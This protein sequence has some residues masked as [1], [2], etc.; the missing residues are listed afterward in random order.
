MKQNFVAIYSENNEINNQNDNSEKNITTQNNNSIIQYINNDDNFIE[1]NVD[2][3]TIV[4][5]ALQTQLSYIKVI[6]LNKKN[7]I[8][9]IDYIEYKLLDQSFKINQFK[10]FG[11]GLF[12][13]F[14]YLLNLLISYG[15]LLIFCFIYIVDIFFEYY[16]KVKEEMN[17]Y[18]YYDILTLT[19]GSQVIKFRKFYI[20]NYGE[21]EFL[22]KY[23]NFD[24]FY[25][26]YGIYYF[27]ASYFIN[28]IFM[29]YLRKDYQK[30]KIEN[31]EINDYTLILSG[32]KI[33]F[34]NKNENEGDLL[35]NKKTLKIN[36]K[37]FE[38]DDVTYTYKSS[39][40]FENLKKLNEN[41]E[42]CCCYKCYNTRID[43]RKIRCDLKKIWN[44]EKEENKLYIITFNNKKDY[45]E[46][47]KKYSHS[48]FTNFLCNLCKKEK[49]FIYI[50]KAPKP[51]DILWENLENG[52]EYEYF[53][54]KFW[55]ILYFFI[56]LSFSFV[57]NIVQEIILSKISDKIKDSIGKKL[58]RIISIILNIILGFLL[59][60][61][62]EKYSSYLNNLLENK[63]NFW[64]NSEIKFNLI[65][66]NSIFKFISKGLFPFITNMIIEKDDEFYEALV[67]KMFTIIEMDG[68]GYPMIDLICTV[69]KKGKEMYEK[70]KTIL[71]IDNINNVIYDMNN[72]PNG[73]SVSELKKIYSKKEMELDENYSDII[74]IYWISMF[75]MSIYPVGMIQ[76]FLNLLFKYIIEKNFLMYIYKRPEFINPKIGFFCF[77]FAN[78]GFFFFLFG[79]Y[80]FFKNE[81]N[82]NCFGYLYILVMILILIFPFFLLGKLF[83]IIVKCCCLKEKIQENEEIKNVEKKFKSNYKIFE[84]FFVKDFIIKKFDYF[85]ENKK[86]QLLEESQIEKLRK[87]LENLKP[88][89]LYN[90]Q[91]KLRT[92]KFMEFEEKNDLYEEPK[93][94]DDEKKQMYLFLFELELI[95]YIEEGPKKKEILL[96]DDIKSNSLKNLY[97]QENLSIG[98][99]SYFCTFYDNNSLKMAYIYKKEEDKT[100][101][102]KIYDVFN[103]RVLDKDNLNNLNKIICIDCFEKEGSIFIVTIDLNNEMKIYDTKQKM[104]IKT[105]KNV[106]DDFDDINKNNFFSLS[107]VKH[108]VYNKFD[109]WIITSYNQ[110][111]YFK[112]F[113][114]NG[115]LLGKSESLQ[116]QNQNII[117]IQSLYYTDANC[118][119]CVRTKNKISLYINEIFIRDI[120][121]LNSNI[122]YYLNFKI[123][124]INFI[125]KFI[126]V[127]CIQKDLT[128]YFLYKIEIS[129]IFPMLVLKENANT[130]ANDFFSYSW[131]NLVN[132]IINS[133]EYN[134]DIDTP[135]NEEIKNKIINNLPTYE[136]SQFN[137]GVSD[138]KK[139]I[140]KNKE[141]DIDD[142]YNIGN[143]L[144]WE[145]N[146]LIVGTPFNFFHVIDYEKKTIV[147]IISDSE[148]IIS[149]NISNVIDDPNYG[150][151][152]IMRDNKG[153]IQYIRPAVIRDKLNYKIY[154]SN[155]YFNE[156]PDEKKL[157]FINFS[158]LFY[159]L[160][161][162]LSYTLPL[163]CG[164]ISYL[165]KNE[166]KNKHEYYIFY[167]FYI[168]F[169]MFF[170][171]CV[172]D[173]CDNSYSQKKCCI[174]WNIATLILKI[175]GHCFVA[176]R[177]CSDNKNGLIFI[178]IL[179]GMFLIHFIT[180]FI[181]YYFK[182]KFLLKNYWLNFLFYQ[183]SRFSILLFF[184]LCHVYNI[185]YFETYI[186][187]FILS[188][189]SI[190]IFMSNYFYMFF[191]GIFYSSALQAIFNFPFEWLNLCCVCCKDPRNCVKNYDDQI[192]YYGCI[193]LCSENGK[194]WIIIKRI[195][196]VFIII[197][198]L[199]LCIGSII[200]FI[201]LIIFI[202][203]RYN[204]NKDK[205]EENNRILYG[206]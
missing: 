53:K 14:L 24:V 38:V 160:Y 120:I 28:I 44:K 68:F 10:E 102:L 184:I 137:F 23:Q 132:Y 88:I 57:I 70:S 62:D 18:Y 115:E 29:L 98:N 181:I 167:A 123:L 159:L 109:F 169:G 54:N 26:K 142:K 104:I 114:S 55:K 206:N 152:F 37:I 165:S 202:Y 148:N 149:Y 166:K 198:L 43:I 190:Y 203:W 4:N 92:Q 122:D 41:N 78:I 56:F 79:N 3:K 192:R 9:K 193:N 204:K 51:E 84:P 126:F 178:S 173:I 5:D 64:S 133:I 69:G 11:Y 135:I 13:F 153:K 176:Y 95:N 85:K 175:I 1:N 195:F 67:S 151:S 164:I 46:I 146:Y 15:I 45:D 66:Y 60:K 183:I 205:I 61:L 131:N 80:I 90:I 117:S 174:G 40:Y 97:M 103:K 7:E 81:Y 163:L 42:N 191:K 86:K 197:F 22:K 16:K 119:I 32:E 112:I 127:S 12:V 188:I 134:N 140:Y 162:V 157:K 63:S 21:N 136:Y 200:L 73:L 35:K 145:K 105:I 20:E 52:L 116:D 48:Y 199:I 155:E 113:D 170:K 172:Y 130:N 47:Y 187:A 82:K 156:L 34:D 39:E 8:P 50:T 83:E 168:C 111:S 59:D 147:G 74:S 186:F 125:R 91:N 124:E 30:F 77:N 121:N 72:N 110:N 182:I 33:N 185:K 107:I 36:G 106:G 177:F 99:S 31:P 100:Y 201:L 87:N 89:E 138:E 17:E 6:I 171:G 93:K 150:E 75:Y 180:N 161:S 65:I 25:I 158:M 139:K 179:Y 128:I 101:D 196:M 154:Q 143:I 108:L 94:V 27:I 118:F 129:N 189:I 144:Y 141:I 71:S 194:C 76:S 58:E 2:Y 19:S 96:N 49:K